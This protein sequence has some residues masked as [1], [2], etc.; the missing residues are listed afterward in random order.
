M[1]SYSENLLDKILFH[2][3]IAHSLMQAYVMLG[4]ADHN[5]KSGRANLI[6]AQVK[7]LLAQVTEEL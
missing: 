2:L 7:S 3:L 6:F 4:F 5:G 1:R